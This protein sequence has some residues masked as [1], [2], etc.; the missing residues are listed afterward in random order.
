MDCVPRVISNAEWSF[1]EE[2]LTQ[3]LKALNLFL[4]DVYN[5]GRIIEDGVIPVDVVRE[6]P[7][8]RVEMRG[9]TAPH[10]T[11][12]SICGHRLGSY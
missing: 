12:V 2:G 3:R 8:Y 6:C 10:G 5:Q 1:L 4:E 9:F 11:W 7:Q